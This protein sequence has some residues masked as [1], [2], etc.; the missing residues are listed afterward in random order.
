MRR[1]RHRLQLGWRTGALRIEEKFRPA[2]SRRFYCVDKT[3]SRNAGGTGLG[4][5]IVK[6]IV[7]Q[8]RGELAVE[9]EIGK[10][11]TFRILL[12]AL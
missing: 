5:A 2:A 6:H 1:C 11:S 12:P 10:G 8:H 7:R 9:S 3:R 4:L